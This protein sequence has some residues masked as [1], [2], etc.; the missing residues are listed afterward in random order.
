MEGTW[1]ADRPSARRLGLGHLPAH[2][3]IRFPETRLGSRVTAA[4][5]HALVFP[6]HVV[7]VPWTGV[8]SLP[9]H[10]WTKL[11]STT[12]TPIKER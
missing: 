11:A 7:T 1:V 5:D 2:Q 9:A 3:V 8:F 6:Y 4:L 10:P 12:C